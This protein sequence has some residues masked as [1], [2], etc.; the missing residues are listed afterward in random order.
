MA[1]QSALRKSLKSVL[2]VLKQ[3]AAEGDA[4]A[5]GLSI[6]LK[7]PTFVVTLLVLSD[8]LAILV[9][10]S[11]M[12]QPNSLNLISIEGLVHDYTAALS[13][14]KEDLLVVEPAH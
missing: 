5:L 4:T 7:K 12:F 14:L 13:R 3:I 1:V 6:H 11:L 9:K 8:I 10:M 2:L